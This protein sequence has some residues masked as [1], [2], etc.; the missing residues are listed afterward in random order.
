MADASAVVKSWIKA[1]AKGGVEG[2]VQY[3]ASKID[4]L[5][6]GVTHEESRLAH[7]RS[8]W[9]GVHPS[10]KYK[11]KLVCGDE[12]TAVFEFSAQM[13]DGEH[14][15]CGVFKVARGRITSVHWYGDA[16]RGTQFASNASRAGK[17]ARG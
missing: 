1:V 5:E 10:F 14:R 2:S 17:R 3:L 13:A 15:F 8:R 11:A 4:W 9:Q 7:P 16:A 6:N 12:R